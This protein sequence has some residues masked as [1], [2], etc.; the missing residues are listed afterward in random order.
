M[1]ESDYSEMPVGEGAE[2]VASLPKVNEAT[3]F[4]SLLGLSVLLPFF[5][6]QLVTGPLVNALLFI[7]VVVLG[8]RKAVYIAFFPSVVA[9]AVGL[10]PLVM[11]PMIP[12]I[13]ISNIIL[14]MIFHALWRK[15]Y[16]LGVGVAS[17]AKFIFLF[18]SAQIMFNLILKKDLAGPMASVFSW[19]QLYTALLGGVVAYIFLKF[20]KRI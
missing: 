4:L 3:A 17:V 20:V 16:W 8:W 9:F 5:H 2:Q 12:F 7:A 19:P 1:Q 14:I 6:F 13:I 18:G 15:N 10:L 11:G